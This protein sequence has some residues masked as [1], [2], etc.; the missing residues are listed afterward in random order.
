MVGGPRTF[1]GDIWNTNT[2]I[3]EKDFLIKNGTIKVKFARWY[4]ILKIK[5]T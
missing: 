4:V 2:I 5:L 3:L 1:N